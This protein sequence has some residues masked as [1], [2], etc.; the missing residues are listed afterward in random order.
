MDAD[1]GGALGG[2]KAQIA[3]FEKAAPS[4]RD[5]ESMRRF[6]EDVGLGHVAR[7]VLGAD[8]GVE[9]VERVDRAQRPVVAVTRQTEGGASV[10]GV[11]C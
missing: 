7:G 2:E 5:T 10:R 9:P 3:V 6:E 4:A 8:D 1:R 11:G